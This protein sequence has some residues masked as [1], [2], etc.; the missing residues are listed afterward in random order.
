MDNLFKLIKSMSKSEKRHFKLF[1]QAF[2]SK[3]SIYLQLFEALEKQEE[4]D[5]DALLKKLPIKHLTANKKYLFE[6]ILKALRI[7]HSETNVAF[8][9]L[10]NFQSISLLRNR[11]LLKDAIKIY[12]KTAKKLEELHLYTFLIELL[13]TG[14][15]LYLA[16][17]PNK[18]MPDKVEEVQKEKLKYIKYLE[19]IVSYRMLAREIKNLLRTLHPIRNE[20]H[21]AEVL[22]FLEHPLLAHGNQTE[23]IIAQSMYYECKNMLNVALLD[24][25]KVKNGAK[26]AIVFLEKQTD[27]SPLYSETLV[28]NLVTALL[29]CAKL[30]D[31]VTFEEL[32]VKYIRLQKHIK[33]D[34]RLGKFFEV[35][36]EKLYY[37]YMT[38]YWMETER[39]QDI[40]ELE[41]TV[42]N[43][44]KTQ[45]AFLDTDWRM[46]LGFCF[47]QAFF[48]EGQL[49]KAQVWVEILLEEE[50]NNPKVA[51]ICNAR[52]LN[53]MLQ[54]EKKNYFL[55]YS[56]F[57]STKRYLNK[58]ERIFKGERLMLNFFKWVGENDDAPNLP[59]K[60]E[61]LAQKLQDLCQNKYEKN[62]FD[63]MKLGLWLKIQQS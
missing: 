15:T 34:G 62:F 37:N 36:M 28:V 2:G 48:F 46:T 52:I 59:E 12:E 53:L 33:K 41:P 40:I 45:K 17:L 57:C 39:F 25:E 51:C 4:Y 20:E 5:E 11:G 21:E 38:H 16:H 27:R 44:W 49:D 43:F 42:V 26:E 55:L 13:N 30:K 18:D 61:K 8:Q 56:L 35:I 3:N 50:R 19:H 23:T 6:N 14:E 60:F 63:E 58:S 31:E 9:L 7:Y 10:D 54:Y 47:A 24:F 29:A 32:S 1:T 22:A